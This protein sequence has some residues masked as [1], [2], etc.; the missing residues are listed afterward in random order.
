MG[1]DPKDIRA[2]DPDVMKLFFVI[3][4][5]VTPLEQIAHQIRE[6]SIPEFVD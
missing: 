2:D 3:V 5:G 4:P 1:I 6:C